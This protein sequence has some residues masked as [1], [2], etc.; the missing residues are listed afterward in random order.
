MTRWL[1]GVD[2]D[3]R[4]PTSR[5][6]H[7]GA[8]NF[9]VLQ[10]H[11]A[12]LSQLHKPLPALDLAPDDTG[13]LRAD[14]LGSHEPVFASLGP[15]HRSRAQ[16]TPFQVPLLEFQQIPE[17]ELVLLKKCSARPEFHFAAFLHCVPKAKMEPEVKQ[18]V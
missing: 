7:E 10:R 1:L 17:S 11:Q 18:L 4:R 3:G 15:K 8:V 6:A 14:N 12:F 2:G 5:Q 16:A 13:E 9:L